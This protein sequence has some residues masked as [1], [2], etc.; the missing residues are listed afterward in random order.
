MFIPHSLLILFHFI[1]MN[2]LFLVETT[3]QTQFLFRAPFI[4]GFTM[5]TSSRQPMSSCLFIGHGQH[6]SKHE[7][8][9]WI[10]RYPWI[11][12]PTASTWKGP[13]ESSRAWTRAPQFSFFLPFL[14]KNLFIYFIL[15]GTSNLYSQP[16]TR[17]LGFLFFFWKY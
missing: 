17:I 13:T 4:L 8:P 9:N 14:I 7:L 16:T 1:P 3:W 6:G 10:F 5:W 2:A 15:C 11:W 12:T